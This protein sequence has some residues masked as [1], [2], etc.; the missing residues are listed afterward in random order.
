MKCRREKPGVLEVH[1]YIPTGWVQLNAKCIWLF[2][3]PDVDAHLNAL[4]GLIQ[5]PP[6]SCRPC[7][8]IKK[9]FMIISIT[10]VGDTRDSVTL[11]GECR[12]DV[13]SNSEIY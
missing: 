10:A 3:H 4:C 13:N 6:H 7:N 2:Y 5:S 12:R 8:S 1:I 11:A 9:I